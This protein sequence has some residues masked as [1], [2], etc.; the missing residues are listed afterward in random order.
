MSNKVSPSIKKLDSLDAYSFSNRERIFSP[1]NLPESKKV[2]DLNLKSIEETKLVN[3]TKICQ[4]NEDSNDSFYLNREINVNNHLNEKNDSKDLKDVKYLNDFR[5][6]NEKK[7]TPEINEFKKPIMLN[8][9]ILKLKEKKIENE[10]KDGKDLNNNN[11]QDDQQNQ[12]DQNDQNDQ[13]Q[14][15]KLDLNSILQDIHNFDHFIE[16]IEECLSISKNSKIRE[17][18][19][20]TNN[21]KQIASVLMTQDSTHLETFDNVKENALEKCTPSAQIDSYDK[22]KSLHTGE[23]QSSQDKLQFSNSRSEQILLDSK[24]HYRGNSF[25]IDNKLSEKN[26][27]I[28]SK[29]NS[30][31]N[32]CNICLQKVDLIRITK[33]LVFKKK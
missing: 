6:K 18:D 23:A 15:N 14:N 13:S 4:N 10:V 32:E 24:Q 16:S 30:G 12:K 9:P 31:T 27:S 21:E 28:N 7:V 5:D 17:Y 29:M 19:S 1:T 2:K 11:I 3:N 20:N 22:E 8:Q 25:G 26:V 33:Y